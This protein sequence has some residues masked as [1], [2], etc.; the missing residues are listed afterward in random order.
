MY[1]LLRKKRTYAIAFIVIEK[2]LIMFME[3][4]AIDG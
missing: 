3:G 2:Y 1:A 4:S